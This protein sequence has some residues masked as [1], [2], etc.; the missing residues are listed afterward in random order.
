MN[1]LT[2]N[3]SGW[4]RTC[5]D[6]SSKMT[7]P[8]CQTW[9]ALR[10]RLVAPLDPQ[11]FENCSS[12]TQEIALR[13][14]IL[15]GAVSTGALTYLRPTKVLGGVAL[16][17]IGSKILRALGFSLQK[18][19]YTHVRGEGTEK[20]IDAS[21]IKLMSWNI[22]GLGGGLALDHGGLI[23]WRYRFENIAQTIQK[24]NPDVLILQEVI[25]ASLAE[26]LIEKFKTEYAHFFIHQGANLL[27]VGSGLMVFS[28]CAIHDF[29]YTPFTT[30]TW[31]LNKGFST[32]ELK[33]NPQ[34]STPVVRIIGT[35]LLYGGSEESHEARVS[36]VA[37][38][39]NSVA[40]R[41]L[42]LP[43]VVAGDFNI[44]RDDSRGAFLNP[45]FRHGYQD[46]EY[47]CTNKLTA[48]WDPE[49]AK[50]PEE[51]IDY[52]SLMKTPEEKGVSLENVSLV[53]AFDDTYNTQT[54]R[55]DHHGLIADIR[56]PS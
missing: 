38:I 2:F 22:C 33:A 28:K 52:I 51:I 27:G 19:N 32:I 40:Q 5:L 34:D 55:S 25:D 14:F 43:T 10:Y 56:C 31:E 41:T 6:L 54:A 29:A 21:K 13:S 11:K 3:R 49:A 26:A 16:F 44:E 36:Q 8:F 24:E 17:G 12:L 39:T 46:S 23:D 37:Q 48:Q 1:N 53:E 42:K 35:H 4:D 47:T 20:Q 45:L 7:E 50:S 18:D 15:V 9:H 30:N